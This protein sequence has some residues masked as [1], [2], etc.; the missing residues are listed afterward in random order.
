MSQPPPGVVPHQHCEICGKA[1]KPDVR[2]CSKPCEDQHEENQAYKKKQ[3]WKLLAII[4]GIL[5]LLQLVRLGI[6]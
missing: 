1:V 3:M 2:F 6:I 5:L 4:V